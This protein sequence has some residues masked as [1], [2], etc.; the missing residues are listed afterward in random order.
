VGENTLPAFLAAARDGVDGVE[1]DVRG[2]GDGR[3]AV[4]HDG[5]FRIGA[6]T[7]R[8]G[9]RDYSSLVRHA[10]HPPP[11][12]EQV[13]E[14]LPAHVGVIIEIKDPELDAAVVSAIA[15]TRAERRLAWVL[16]ASFR[17]TV[18]RKVA[19]R[20]PHLRRALIVWAGG[21]LASLRRAAFPLAARTEALAHDLMPHASL[22]TDRLVSAMA[23]SGGRVIP[24]TVNDA[25]QGDRLTSAGVYGIISDTPDI[26]SASAVA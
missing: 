22:V 13:L 1:L 3:L 9:A 4:F 23:V 14:A 26:F 15:S 19:A 18:L 21:N 6:R 2:T 20:A 8:V 12:L 10:P 5:T 7:V 25:A 17:P 11:V 24:W 16:V